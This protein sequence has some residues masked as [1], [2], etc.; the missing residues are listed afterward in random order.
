[1]TAF[2]K[3]YQQAIQEQE[4]AKQEQVLEKKA[5]SIFGS[6]DSG[7]EDQRPL[8]LPYSP[9]L[10]PRSSMEFTHSRYLDSTGMYGKWIY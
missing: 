10:T 5:G 6:S 3:N 4:Q 8:K 1:M 7:I 9:P 2:Y